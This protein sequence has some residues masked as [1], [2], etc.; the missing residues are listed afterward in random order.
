MS[1]YLADRSVTKKINILF[2]I[3]ILYGYGG[4][5]RHLNYLVSMLDKSKYNCIIVPFNVNTNY[6]KRLRHGVKIVP[7]KIERYSPF[8]F[9]NLF[10][11]ARIMR[12]NDIDIVQTFHFFSDTLGVLV[13]KLASVK[14]VISSRRDMGFKKGKFHLMVNKIMNRHIDKFITV[15]DAVGEWIATNENVPKDRQVTIRNGIDLALFNASTCDERKAIRRELGINE[16]DFVVGIVGHIR[17]EKGHDM[18]LRAACQLTRRIPNARFVIVGGGIPQ[19]HDTYRLFVKE[20]GF[21]DRTLFTGYVDDARRYIQTFDVACLTSTTEGFS[22]AILEYMALEKP[23]VATTVGGNREVIVDGYNGYGVPPGS[24]DALAERLLYMYRNP[25]HRI[26]MGR[27]GRKTV[28]ERFTIEKMIAAHSILYE[29]MVFGTRA[30]SRVACPHN[31]NA[32]D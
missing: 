4:T 22:N 16:A 5:E 23:V 29:E 13:S 15:S 20:N 8:S 2:L 24:P 28:E 9:I 32:A 25:E 21:D 10:R 30:R 11:L 1:D 3:D 27:Q 31:V 17:P 14:S 26:T 6:L 7:I 12:D 19:L 18:F